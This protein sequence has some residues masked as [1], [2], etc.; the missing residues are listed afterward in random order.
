MCAEINATQELQY[1]YPCRKLKHGILCTCQDM[2]E[3][4]SETTSKPKA[5]ECKG[6]RKIFAY[7]LAES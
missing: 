4:I 3:P 6:R 1:R 7:E 5:G 2:E